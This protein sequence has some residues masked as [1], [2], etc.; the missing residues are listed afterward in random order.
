M[1]HHTHSIHGSVAGGANDAELVKRFIAGTCDASERGRVARFLQL[2]PHLIHRVAERNEASRKLPH[3]DFQEI[4][5]IIDTN[6]R[7]VCLSAEWTEFASNN[8]EPAVCSPRKPEEKS[9]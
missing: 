2:H 7:L 1:N 9:F 8:D 5:Y 3:G 4:S 6:D